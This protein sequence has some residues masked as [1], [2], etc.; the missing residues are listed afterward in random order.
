MQIYGNDKKK[1]KMELRD[2]PIQQ[3][4]LGRREAKG[5]A[6]AAARGEGGPARFQASGGPRRE[7]G[8]GRDR[9]TGQGPQG[10]GGLLKTLLTRFLRISDLEI[11]H[12]IVSNF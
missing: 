12:S 4:I 1:K 5:M 6:G 9:T 2:C 3:M 10:A 7:A 8:P 11:C